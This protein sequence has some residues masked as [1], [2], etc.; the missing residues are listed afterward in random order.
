MDLNEKNISNRKITNVY[1][2]HDNTRLDFE[3]FRKRSVEFEN[4]A[5]TLKTFVQ[6]MK[7]IM[8][9]RQPNVEEPKEKRQDLGNMFQST[10][11]AQEEME[12][13]I[14]FIEQPKKAINE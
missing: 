9:N 11:A 12:E 6:E 10:P 8:L 5:S 2:L 13:V 4:S 7:D 14:P 1:V 3:C